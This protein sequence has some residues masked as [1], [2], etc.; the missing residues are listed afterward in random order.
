MPAVDPKAV[1]EPEHVK[2]A[3]AH[4]A[5]LGLREAALFAW[6]Y[7]FGARA[8]EPG[9]QNISDV[10]VPALRA[11]AIH[12]K[13]KQG[14]RT[15]VPTRSDWHALLPYCVKYLPPWLAVQK[16]ARTTPLFPTRMGTRCYTCQ[17][18]GKRPILRKRKTG[19]RFVDGT[20]VCHHCSGTGARAGISR[21][22]VHKL[23]TAILEAAG[24]PASRR[25]PHVLRHTI[26]THL[27]E[28]GM[29]PTTV[30]DRVGH[31]ALQTTLEYA[32]ATRAAA[33]Q[34]EGALRKLGMYE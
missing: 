31:A 24:A 14:L 30:Q 4:A 32:R 25:H 6:M 26:I 29:A 18:T 33:A 15:G 16:G 2:K 23:I 28:G 3:M 1:L 5:T 22:E 11:R 21:V 12:L 27:L 17:G 8:G 9:L 34:M 20:A 13:T 19:G 7:E 10:D